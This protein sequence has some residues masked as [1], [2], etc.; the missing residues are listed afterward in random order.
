MSKSIFR[1]ALIV[2]AA[3]MLIC[4]AVSVTS[5]AAADT[6]TFPFPTNTH[7]EYF[8][9]V[10]RQ[11]LPDGRI[12]FR[13][14]FKIKD[15]YVKDSAGSH[16]ARLYSPWTYPSTAMTEIFDYPGAE[17]GYHYFIWDVELM[18]SVGTQV[19][20]TMYYY[21]LKDNGANNKRTTV[22]KLIYTM[23]ED[24]IPDA[25]LGLYTSEDGYVQGLVGDKAYKYAPA[26]VTPD[27]SIKYDSA[28]LL[29]LTETT[30]LASGHWAVVEAG[31]G[32]TYTNSH[33]AHITVLLPAPKIGAYPATDASEGGLGALGGLDAAL[34]YDYKLVADA[35]WTT[36]TGET[37]LAVPAGK[38]EIRIA[39]TTPDTVA[40]KIAEVEVLD[41]TGDNAQY[42]SVANET[43]SFYLTEDFV[44][45]SATY[46]IDVTK[47]TWV[48]KIVLDNIKATSP[49]ATI[50]FKGNGY[51]YEVLASDLKTVANVHYYNFDVSFNGTSRHDT[52]FA[53]LKAL[54]EGTYV[55]NYYFE[56]VNALPF[57]KATFKVQLG[58][59]YNGMSVTS[60]KLN[61][62]TGRLSNGETVTVKDGWAD[63]TLI[64]QTYVITCDEM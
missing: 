55:T 1:K 57:E 15:G 23:T 44:L 48:S 11:L 61:D 26:S 52:L 56:S 39:R 22:G 32:K 38:Y 43:K 27:G 58:E 45:A 63:F 20:K 59:K 21:T 16:N 51:Q 40:S 54:A 62:V 28:E 60:K 12:G 4:T 35:E 47:D 53:Q 29:P 31:D 24:Y 49:N 6:T 9:A 2:L 41:W 14:T 10:D 34:T 37:N 17:E 46:E 25:P 7:A 36:V 5:L 50:V 64:D 13:F 19:S 42:T 18:D 33:P 30:K 3:I 8:S